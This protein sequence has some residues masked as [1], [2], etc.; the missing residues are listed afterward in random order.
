MQQKQKQK[1]KPMSKSAHNKNQ[2]INRGVSKIS[3]RI[4]RERGYS[5]L[6]VRFLA[7]TWNVPRSTL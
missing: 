6:S 5:S 3:Q 7:R 1:Q 2:S 4:S